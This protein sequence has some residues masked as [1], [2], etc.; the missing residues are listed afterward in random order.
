MLQSSLFS[1]FPGLTWSSEAAG[2]PGGEQS[3]MKVQWQP[4]FLSP[5]FINHS[6]GSSTQPSDREKSKREEEENM[7]EAAAS[8]FEEVLGQVP[9]KSLLDIHPLLTPMPPQAIKSKNWFNDALDSAGYKQEMC[10]CQ[11]FKAV[12]FC[13]AE[14][15]SNKES[16]RQRA[17][18]ALVLTAKA[19]QEA[20]NTRIQ[21][22]F[23]F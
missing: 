1:T 21:G 7:Y 11:A 19:F 22:R 5:P 4:Q 18:D 8:V 17:S 13:L 6:A 14:M 20:R 12:M 2:L 3:Q 15:D 23:G 10:L 16:A 9:V